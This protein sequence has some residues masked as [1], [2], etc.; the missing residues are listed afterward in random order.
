MARMAFLYSDVFCQ[1]F[2]CYMEALLQMRS[3]SC[4]LAAAPSSCK[5]ISVTAFLRESFK[6][7]LSSGVK[8]NKHAGSC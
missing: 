3:S 8:A 7:T 4:L 5:Q 1:I 2:C 6:E